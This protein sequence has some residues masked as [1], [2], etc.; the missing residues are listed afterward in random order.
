[1]KMFI[2][3][4]DTT[5]LFSDEQ[6]L[7]K[8]LSGERSK[9]LNLNG[10]FDFKLNHVKIET[11]EVEVL[12]ETI[13]STYLDSYIESTN[14]QTKVMSILGDE[15][16][17]KL[18]KFK[19]MFIEFAKDD[20]SKKRFLQELETV[21]VDKKSLSKLITG[22]VGYLF[23]VN[24]SVEWFKTILSIHNFRKIEDSY[25]REVFYSNGIARYQNIKVS[26][27]AKLNFNKA[28]TKN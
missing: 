9:K 26:E 1:M 13:A 27:E 11:V 21:L 6:S 15:L 23:S 19:S 4:S 8:Y 25:P 10:K 22:W 18:Q 16:S 14:R 17:Q 12:E 5:K 3:H 2:V 28:K 7:I 24:D 20:I